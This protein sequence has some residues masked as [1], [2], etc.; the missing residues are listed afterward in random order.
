MFLVAQL[1]YVNTKMCPQGKKEKK[2]T[3]NQKKKVQHI[4]IAWLLQEKTTIVSSKC[5]LSISQKNITTI[6]CVSCFEQLIQKRASL[7][8]W[9]TPR[10]VNRYDAGKMT[11]TCSGSPTQCCACAVHRCS[12]QDNVRH[13]LSGENYEGKAVKA[14][15]SIYHHAV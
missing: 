5:F 13:R 15:Y 3:L 4:L 8:C 6:C 11:G 2:S 10:W 14:I 12:Q 1:L 7:Q 9:H